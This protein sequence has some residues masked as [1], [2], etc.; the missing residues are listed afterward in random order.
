MLLSI[1]Y[2]SAQILT[3]YYIRNL[4][5]CSGRKIGIEMAIDDHNLLI[6][7][8]L[9]LGEGFDPRTGKLSAHEDFLSDEAFADFLAYHDRGWSRVP[10]WRLIIAGD[11]FELLQVTSRSAKDAK[12]LSDRI[13][14][15]SKGAL[16]PY[17]AIDEPERRVEQ[18]VARL[19]EGVDFMEQEGGP[20][21]ASVVSCAERLVE[22]AG[23][24]ET[25][26]VWEFER[27]SIEVWIL[28]HK[29]E[30]RL[31]DREWD[32]GLGTSWPEAVWK[33][34]RIA[35]GHPAFFTALASFLDRGHSLVMMKGNHDIELYWPQVQE[36]LRELLEDAH[37]EL[38]IAQSEA[39][40]G[41]KQLAMSA[42]EFRVAARSKFTF[43]P[44][45][46]YEHGRL[47]LEHGNQYEVADAFEDFI[48][49]TL[50]E[51]RGHL[52]R[53]PPGSFFVRYFFNKV[54]NFM[55]FIDNLRPISRAISWVFARHPFEAI[56]LLWR[57]RSGQNEFAKALIRRGL[58]DAARHRRQVRIRTRSREDPDR[59]D[60][61]ELA[62][63]IK[64][65]HA[66]AIIL[67]R[68]GDGALS[69]DWQLKIE[70][71]ALKQRTEPLEMIL[72]WIRLS[73]PVLLV[74]G[75]IIT[76]V[77]IFVLPGV[78]TFLI[79]DRG[80]SFLNNYLIR[81]V[82]IGLLGWIG[83]GLSNW[84][85]GKLTHGEDYLHKASI[86]IR[87]AFLEDGE[88][89]DAPNAKYFVFGHTHDPNA[90][91]LDEAGN[92]PWYVNTGSWL[93]TIS[94]IES[95][96]QLEKDFAFL[97]IAPSEPEHIP[98]LYRWNPSTRQPE[99]IRL[100]QQE[101]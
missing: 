11:V 22:L 49:P 74:A 43:C 84:V 1:R 24:L 76:L 28:A 80:T 71:L 72:E 58:A 82:L 23:S 13:E 64:R 48:H 91:R 32:Y 31:S 6:V 86:R 96:S 68:A 55:P 100:R 7:S 81:L 53:L 75:S 60:Q 38:R 41:A 88:S 78:L 65:D 33:I 36:R 3:P 97:R 99:R 90:I 17:K 51:P 93:S 79:P 26:A 87:E 8:D 98:G 18:A 19:Q 45:I 54:E 12:Q 37:A 89:S 4:Y 69:A 50:D 40:E 16:A 30:A 56:K 20:P 101:G 35:E 27:L 57:Y 44:W 92:G 46:Y 2:P 14:R 70:D 63:L 77:L 42:S 34:D 52:L 67:N 94:E 59:V 21:H 85:V 25:D 61:A 62:D 9:H 39:S 66:R 29:P 95:W 10:P 83:K 15:L 5:V 47:Y 73:L